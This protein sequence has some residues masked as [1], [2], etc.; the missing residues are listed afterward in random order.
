MGQIAEEDSE[1]LK[2]EDK[3][4]GVGRHDGWD[5][6]SVCIPPRRTRC[7][8]GACWFPMK[9]PILQPAGTCTCEAEWHCH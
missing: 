2:K 3:G 6:A 1:P 8:R 5:L 7:G 4:S 9:L